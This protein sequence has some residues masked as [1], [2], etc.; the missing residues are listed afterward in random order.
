MAGKGPGVGRMIGSGGMARPHVES[1]LLAR[2]IKK[3]QVYSPTKAHREEYAREIREQFGLEVVPLD[4]PRDVYK[5]AD[6]I[7]GCTDSA[8]PIIFGDCLEDGTHI[9]CVGG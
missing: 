8:V 5:G 7:A 3:I 1:F 4:N 9:T 2:K 6:I